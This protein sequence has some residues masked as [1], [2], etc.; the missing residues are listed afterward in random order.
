MLLEDVEYF[1]D[2]TKAK[3][4]FDMLD[5]DKDG[6]ISLQVCYDALPTCLVLH[7]CHW[8]CQLDSAYI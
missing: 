6:K 3:E 4:C 1:L 5:L 7:E 2:K 8:L